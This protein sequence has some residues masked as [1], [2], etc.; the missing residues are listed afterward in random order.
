VAAKFVLEQT[1]PGAV[2][3]AGVGVKFQGGATCLLETRR[4]HLPSLDDW[5]KEW[6]ENPQRYVQP[7][8]LPLDFR[9]PLAAVAQT[10]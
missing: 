7:K 9:S 10:N 3:P 5:E 2:R 6:Q 8:L 4:S 1:R